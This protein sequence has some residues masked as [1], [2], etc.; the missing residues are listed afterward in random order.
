ML[1]ER[2]YVNNS[3]S[4]EEPQETIKYEVSTAPVKKL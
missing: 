2:A 1:K 4:L 3:Y